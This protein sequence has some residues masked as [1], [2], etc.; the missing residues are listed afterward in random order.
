MFFAAMQ[1]ADKDEAAFT[2]AIGAHTEGA[3]AQAR[4][5]NAAFFRPDAAISGG[6]PQPE[7][8]L[9]RAGERDGRFIVI[10]NVL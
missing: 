1:S 4:F 2:A 9:D 7:H 10:P 3:A 6:S 5:V 8:L